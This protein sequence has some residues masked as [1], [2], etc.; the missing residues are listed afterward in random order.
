MELK[1]LEVFG[2]KS[3][4]DRTRFD[5]DSG[6]TVIVGPNGCGKSNVVDAVKWVLGEQSAKSLRGRDMADI[7]F[8][9]SESRKS[10]GFAEATLTFDNTRGVLPVDLAEVEVGRRLYRSGE[11]EYLLNRRP[12][13]LRDIRELF[14]DTGVGVDAYSLI[15]QG[16]VDVLL[17]SNPQER[18]LIF[19]EAA[20][21]SKYKAKRKEAERKLARTEQ[22]L[23]RL[24]DIF[25]EVDR[26]L[27]SVKYQAGKARSWKQYNERLKELRVSYA[28]NQY[29][30]HTRAMAAQQTDL[31]RLGDE[32]SA[33]SARL[34]DL[35]R[36][37]SAVETELMDLETGARDAD[38]RL[39]GLRSDIATRTSEIE[40]HRTRAEELGQ[41]VDRD[42]RKLGDLSA[43]LRQ[44]EADVQRRQDEIR[45]VAQAAQRQDLAVQEIEQRLRDVSDQV[46]SL[47]GRIENAKAEM[48]DLAQGRTR[49]ASRCGSLELALE[50]L[51]AQVRKLAARRDEIAG[52]LGQLA[53]R[54]GELRQEQDE[55][56]AAVAERR[57][58]LEAKRHEADERQQ[59][60]NDVADR[61][62]R[63]KEHASA[64]ES[65]RSLL[66][67]LERRGEGIPAAV[68][69]VT[70]AIRAETA[71]AAAAPA[72]DAA[73]AD[74]QPAAGRWHGMVADLIEVDVAHAVMV[75]AALGP[76]EKLLVADRQA[77]VL[78]LARRLEG[79]LPGQVRFLALD[80][81]EPATDGRDLSAYPEVVGWAMDYV[82]ADASVR[83]AVAHLLARTIVVRTLDD[84]ARLGGRG[85]PLAG[86]RFVSLSGG[87]LEADGSIAIGPP[88]PETSLISRRSELR[89]IQRQ[90][91]E[92]AVRIDALDA[93]RRRAVAELQAIDASQQH[94]RQEIYEASMRKVEVESALRRLTDARQELVREAPVVEAELADLADRR[95][96]TA[97]E[98]DTVDR[99]AQDLERRENEKREQV[100]RLS[101]E[102]EALLLRREVCEE[103]RTT[104]RVALAQLNEK[105]AAA[106]D[107]LEAARRDLAGTRQGIDEARQ[108][109]A[110]CGDR[111]RESQRSMLRLQSEL[112]EAFL[113][114]ESAEADVR[115]LAGVRADARRRAAGL[116]DEARGVESEIDQVRAQVHEVELA[117]REL[118][119][120]RDDLAARVRDDFHLDLADEY[121]SWQADEVNWDQVAEGIRDLQGKIERL[122]SVNLEAIDEQEALEQ[123]VDFLRRQRD[124]LTAARETLAGLIERINRESRQ[125]FM[126]TFEAVR[127]HFQELFR[128]LF[129]GGKADV[130]M[131]DEADVLETGIEIVARPPGKQL[132]RISLL[133]GGEKTLTAVALLLAVFRAR[134]SPFAILDEVDAALDETN[135]DRFTALVKDFLDQSQFVIISHS[136]R[137]MAI[138]DVLYGV[139][140]AEP[141]VSRKVSVKFSDLHEKGF[142]TEES[143]A[144]DAGGNGDRA[145]AD[146]S[147]PA[148]E[149]PPVDEAALAD[150]AVS[151]DED[152]SPAPVPVEVAAALSHAGAQ[153]ARRA[154]GIEAEADEA[155]AADAAVQPA[156]AASPTSE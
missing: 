75:E 74:A 40:F 42:R 155:D 151:A 120:K 107:A 80:A 7:I 105:Q 129:G 48:L 143:A 9:G 2:F 108:E 138:A 62:A 110:D 93:D 124:D 56:A 156:E 33:A 147:S 66:E 114:K 141:G 121:A 134:P 30:E 154:D 1:R 71:P 51:D 37:R 97:E 23:L 127:G 145:P 148:E 8:A 79:D 103:E 14:M 13:R 119:T 117:R 65:R 45:D 149:A 21:I 92:L 78:A 132:Q 82:R 123:R 47:T 136:K 41:I 85:G 46:R 35:D 104:A 36:R 61:L 76:A 60:L 118:E 49:A 10:L 135:I 3:F 116:A 115:R 86:Y 113:A 26:R 59:H 57:G 94:L 34:A 22:N 140:M 53:G 54:E 122:G 20:G 95:R 63:A 87:V 19:E 126:S 6:I 112:A 125:R 11:S 98:R 5:F 55:L 100:A 153:A 4:A 144:G 91:D 15:E 142:L 152:V 67:D 101:A 109:L 111:I 69:R 89:D 50:T 83:P 68:R 31:D 52:A 106:G 99:E 72:P 38:A 130:F 150:D 102:Q 73:M 128:K 18:R 44:A 70:E 81:I 137:T 27:R 58:R 77:D 96:Q 133:S 29:H 24:D 16:K 43:H 90:A 12:C 28:L 32:R 146:E 131:E 17:Q 84:A 88:G 64:L 139:T 25:Q 39:S